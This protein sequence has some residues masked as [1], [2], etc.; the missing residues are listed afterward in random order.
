MPSAEP[1]DL[2]TEQWSGSGNDTYAEF[3]SEVQLICIEPKQQF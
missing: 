1:H 3:L 2:L